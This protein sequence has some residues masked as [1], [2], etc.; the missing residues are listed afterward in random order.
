MS[1]HTPLQSH[2]QQIQ[3]E[4]KVVKELGLCPRA[5]DIPETDGKALGRKEYGTSLFQKINNHATR[6]LRAKTSNSSC[7]FFS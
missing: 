4:Q 3:E 2:L 1:Q 5:E 6:K 7:I